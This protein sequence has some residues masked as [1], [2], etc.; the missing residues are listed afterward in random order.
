MFYGG[1]KFYAMQSSER[2]DESVGCSCWC[3]ERVG[4]SS[5]PPLAVDSCCS[6]Q[7]SVGSSWCPGR[8][9]LEQL[10]FYQN[11]LIAVVGLK[12]LSVAVVILSETANISCCPQESVKLAAVF[13]T[14]CKATTARF[15]YISNT[16]SIEGHVCWTANINYRWSFADQEKQTSVSRFP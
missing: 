11:L 2:S 16:I 10:F 1:P 12:T 9:C 8:N 13:P 7:D 15:L 6:P 14:S 5:C 4:S 3:Q